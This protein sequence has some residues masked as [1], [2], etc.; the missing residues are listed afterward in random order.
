MYKIILAGDGRVL[1]A[2]TED[3]AIIG[4]VEVGTLPDGDITDYRYVDGAYV[5]DPEP[6]PE[7]IPTPTLNERVAAVE[8]GQ[9]TQDTAIDELVQ[10]MA[11]MIGGAV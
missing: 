2:A 10:V 6:E 9:E 3:S 1:S 4:A 7:V 8:A 11:D 5:H